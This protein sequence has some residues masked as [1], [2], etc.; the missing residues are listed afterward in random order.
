MV[1]KARLAASEFNKNSNIS[2]NERIGFRQSTLHGHDFYELE[3]ITAGE[4][5]S[6][7]NG[8]DADARRGTVFFMTPADFHEYSSSEGFNIYNIQFTADAISSDILERMVNGKK[9]IFRPKEDIFDK[10]CKIAAIVLE[11]FNSGA[12]HNVITHFFECILLMLENESC[13]IVEKPK[14]KA[15]RCMQKAITYIHAH[16]RENPSLSSVAEQVSFN[17]NYFCACFH[18]YTGMPYKEYLKAL[19]LKYARRLV[20]ATSLPITEIAYQSGY[21]TQSH[22]NREFKDFYGMSP[23]KLR[24]SLIVR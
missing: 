1:G 9:S 17:V 8:K 7:L 16:F 12:N 5:A 4:A 18:A 14:I 15:E 13:G 24:D 19:K 21:R 23:L 3:I 2:I 6:R 22:F 20:L 10:I 11:L